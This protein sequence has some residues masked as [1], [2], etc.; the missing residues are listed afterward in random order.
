MR[1]SKLFFTIC[2]FFCTSGVLAQYAEQK[3][4]HTIIDT[5][6]VQQQLEMARHIEQW[7]P[8]SAI[9]LLSPVLQLS[10]KNSY[11][12][13]IKAAGYELMLLYYKKNELD[14]SIHCCNI[15]L[16]YG[17]IREDNDLI[18]DAYLIK[19]AAYQL[20]ERFSDAL[21]NYHLLLSLP[22]GTK[23]PNTGMQKVKAYNNIAL[24]LSR[25]QQYEKAIK[26]QQM[27]DSIND[28]PDAIAR[29]L[30][31]WADIYNGMGNT[32]K[33]IFFLD[34]AIRLPQADRDYTILLRAQ[35]IIFLQKIEQNKKALA[36]FEKLLP[37]INN[38]SLPETRKNQINLI[39]GFAYYGVRNFAKAKYYL[40]KS[41]NEGHALNN[42][43]KRNILHKLSHTYYETKEYKKAYELHLTFHQLEDSIRS[44]DVLLNA[45]EL[46][47]KYRTA[48]KDKTIMEERLKYQVSRQQ[49]Y[50]E[51]AWSISALIILSL[52]FLVL[53][54][55]YLYI[56]QKKDKLEAHQKL[57]HL[58][59][60]MEG[61]E[62]ERNRMAQELHDGVNSSLAATHSY[63]QAIEQIYPDITN[64]QHFLKVK[65]L[66][67]S[68]SNEIR[69]IAHNL[70]PNTLLKEGLVSAIEEFC[71]N[72]FASRVQVEVQSFGQEYG[73]NENMK[74]LLYRIAQELLHNIYKHA[75]ATEII[76]MLGFQNKDISLTIEDN[77][78]GITPSTD[79]KS[80]IG[81]INIRK[82]LQEHDG[83]ISIETQAGKGTVVHISLPSTPGMLSL[84]EKNSKR[85]N[86]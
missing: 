71:R 74:L 61:E 85:N 82:R 73:H 79:K 7:Y 4:L 54:M 80:G 83:R 11:V 18:K 51:R 84:Y 56:K 19:A 10:L 17:N 86:A 57:N 67:L 53:Y 63:L 8:D 69:T 65:E 5:T 50:K 30:H 13:G 22:P 58:Q 9:A 20:L 45:N 70:T 12:A 3:L 14:K 68:T 1:C 59:A 32:E 29:M 25:M 40:L 23:G 52:L 60:L 36:E 77:G 34:S 24:M 27:A 72:L 64:E 41:Y 21:I 42:S 38:D 62:K 66:L 78:K 33:A 46:E 75:G 15:L 37:Y 43:E 35:K 2:T 6:H 55:R 48:E 16:Q 44:K 39:G 31:T 81:I 76:V 49:Q 26:Y 28:D 47:T